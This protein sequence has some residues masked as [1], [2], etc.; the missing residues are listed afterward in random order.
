MSSTQNLETYLPA[1]DTVP[2]TWEEAHPFF[3]EQLK[4]ISNAVNVREV[5]WYL[6]EEVLTGKQFIPLYGVANDVSGQNAQY[7]S[8]FRKVVDCSPLSAGANSFPHGIDFTNADTSNFSLIQLFGGATDDTGL[9]AIP[10]P[11]NVDSLTMTTTDILINVAS[12]YDR[13]YVTIEYIREK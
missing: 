4:K 9:T 5:G 8:I 13:A 1:Y 10:L 11:N 6:D 2:E 7:R 12:A 3:A